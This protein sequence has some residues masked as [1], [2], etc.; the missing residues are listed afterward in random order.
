MNEVG[1]V[2]E[3]QNVSE[4]MDKILEFPSSKNFVISGFKDSTV[5]FFGRFDAEEDEIVSSVM[6]VAAAYK[7]IVHE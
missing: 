3:D 5:W 4:M 7:K 1:P 6:E 2:D